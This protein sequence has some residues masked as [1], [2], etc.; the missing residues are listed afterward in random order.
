MLTNLLDKAQ[1]IKSDLFASAVLGQSSRSG[2]TAWGSDRSYLWAGYAQTETTG[3][4]AWSYF[5]RLG[6]AGVPAFSAE[7]EIMDD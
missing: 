6:C 4:I 2:K 3:F 7:V 1:E 5:E